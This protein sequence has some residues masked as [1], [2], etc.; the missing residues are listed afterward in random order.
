MAL[1]IA[2]KD[3]SPK[4]AFTPLPWGET[5]LDNRDLNRLLLYLTYGEAVDIFGSEVTAGWRGWQEVRPW[6]EQTIVEHINSSLEFAF[7]KALGQRSISSLLMH[8]VMRMWMWIV[9]DEELVK[10]D[11]NYN[12]Y[13]LAYLYRVRDKYFPEIRPQE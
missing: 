1:K 8:S 6:D 2:F 3:A 10:G 13:G 5:L 9:Q 11:P 12:D 4:K 7:E